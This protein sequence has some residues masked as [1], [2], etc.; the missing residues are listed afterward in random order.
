MKMKSKIESNLTESISSS[1]KSISQ[2][3]IE[4]EVKKEAME[5]Y[6]PLKNEEN[7]YSSS[8]PSKKISSAKNSKE[9][10]KGRKKKFCSICNKTF[11]SVTNLKMH[12]AST[13]E[14]KKSYDC[15]SCSSIFTHKSNLK[16]HF[17]SV[18][19]W[20]KEIKCTACGFI[21]NLESNLK[22]HIASV[23]ERKKPHM[24]HICSNK[25]TNL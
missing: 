5:G 7:A 13:H 25:F 4:I 19:K 10:V 11:L 1:Q 12:R 8:T 18:H 20:Q 15:T 22:R 17:V 14:E 24:C 3:S 2:E 9:K 23:H 16:R 6:C 21:F